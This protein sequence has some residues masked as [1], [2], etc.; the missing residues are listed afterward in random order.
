[1]SHNQHDL[2]D[3][4]CHAALT[5]AVH[6]ACPR[7]AA[8]N[9]GGWNSFNMQFSQTLVNLCEAKETLHKNN[10]ELE[11]LVRSECSAANHV[12]GVAELVI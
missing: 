11:N 6:E 12:A 5:A 7:R 4:E 1:M 3:L 10:T 9:P 2:R 8:R